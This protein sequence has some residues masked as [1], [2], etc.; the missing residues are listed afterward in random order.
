M[1]SASDNASGE[2]TMTSAAVVPL[3]ENSVDVNN[4][5]FYQRRSSGLRQRKLNQVSMDLLSAGTLSFH[6]INY[7]LGET[8]AQSP[9]KPWCSS[10]MKSKPPQQILHDVS[11]IFK[12]GMNAIMGKHEDYKNL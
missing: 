6:H 7:V 8:K 5:N 12:S 2:K 1:A 9:C 4:G 3:L 11:G 10:G